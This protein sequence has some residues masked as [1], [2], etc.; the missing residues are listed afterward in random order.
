MVLNKEVP[1]M[2]CKHTED[3]KDVQQQP[4][5]FEMRY[6]AEVERVLVLRR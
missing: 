3:A 6:V 1:V 2:G 4:S 5:D